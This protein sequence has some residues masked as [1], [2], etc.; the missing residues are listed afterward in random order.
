MDM[1]PMIDLVFLL[2][3]FFMI[4]SQRITYLKDPNVT[5][6]I[7]THSQV[8]REVGD[9]VVINVYA[10]GTIKDVSGTRT[11][12]P[13]TVTAI[14]ESARAENPGTRLHL[15]A[16]QRA[17]HRHV[18]VVMDASAKGGVSNVIFSTYVTDK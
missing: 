11:L 15:R 2:L 14:M 4:V 10:D 13:E 1:S 8:P 18:Q 16:D 17:A 5:I 6:P 12:S 3:I 9:R 7:A